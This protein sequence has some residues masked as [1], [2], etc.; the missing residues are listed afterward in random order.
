MQAQLDLPGTP[1]HRAKRARDFILGAIRERVEQ[2]KAQYLAGSAAKD[3]LL[4]WFASAK[5]AEGDPL[6][7]QE[8]SVRCLPPGRLTRLVLHACAPSHARAVPCTSACER[9]DCWQGMAV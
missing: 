6:D 9:T 3:T 1:F 2:R 4:S 7:T 8:L 5:V